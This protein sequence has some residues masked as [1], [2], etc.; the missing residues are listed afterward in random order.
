MKPSTAN[1]YRANLLKCGSLAKFRVWQA[2]RKK[3]YRRANPAVY[4]AEMKRNYERYIANKNK[5]SLPQ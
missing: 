2:A 4:Q 3:K 1:W 5:G